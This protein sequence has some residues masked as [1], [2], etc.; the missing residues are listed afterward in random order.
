MIKISDLDLS[1]RGLALK[2][3][4]LTALS[5]LLLAVAFNVPALWFFGFIALVPLLFVLKNIEKTRGAVLHGFTFGLIYFGSVLSF[6]F[7]AHPLDWLGIENNTVSLIGITLVWVLASAVLATGPM[8]WATVIHRLRNSRLLFLLAP[9]AWVLSEFFQSTFFSLLFAGENSLIGPHW[10]FGFLG[11]ILAE[12]AFLL[13]LASLGGVFILGFIIVLVN[14]F[15]YELALKRK[16]Q[17]GGVVGAISVLFA[18]SMFFLYSPKPTGEKSVAVFYTDF[19][20]EFLQDLNES[21]KQFDEVDA[22][23]RKLATRGN[24]FDIIVLPENTFYFSRLPQISRSYRLSSLSRHG[25]VVIVDSI[26][27]NSPGTDESLIAFINSERAEVVTRAKRLLVPQGEYLS[28]GVAWLGKIFLGNEWYELFSDRRALE[29]GEEMA[30]GHSDETAIGALFCSE[31]LTP[32]IYR[33]LTRA[34]A[35]ILTNSASHSVFTD[36][37]NLQEQIVKYSKLRAVESGRYYVQ[38]GNRVP[39]FVLS[40]KGEL[41]EETGRGES[42]VLETK[43]LTY[44]YRTIFSVVGTEGVLGLFIILF[45]L[46]LLMEKRKSNPQPQL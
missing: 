37:K 28:Y 17:L 16:V 10:T 44:N 29:R 30:L 14:T 42:M 11:Y 1:K 3:F 18:A 23:F 5:G 13:S 32:N 21:E 46:L 25:E 38:A 7:S 24:H 26:R 9:T 22:M 6:L 45:F 36:S 40:R 8:L 43:V 12:N 4:S 34:G 39:S 31:V 33:D 20:P 2:R 41:L 19:K 35:E 27:T 15:F